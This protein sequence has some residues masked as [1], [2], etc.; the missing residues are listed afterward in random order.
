VAADLYGVTHRQVDTV[1]AS[2]S[3]RLNSLGRLSHAP[4]NSPTAWTSTLESNFQ[5][6]RPCLRSSW[7]AAGYACKPTEAGSQANPPYDRTISRCLSKYCWQYLA[8]ATPSPLGRLSRRRRPEYGCR[9]E[10][11]RS[12]SPCLPCC[13]RTLWSRCECRSDAPRICTS[14]G[15]SRSRTRLSHRPDQGGSPKER[16][17]SAGPI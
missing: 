12:R 3:L 9:Q 2:S 10:W 13:A 5:L 8:W 15:W 1:D 6:S 7:T 11:S 17:R 14:P 16:E 4:P